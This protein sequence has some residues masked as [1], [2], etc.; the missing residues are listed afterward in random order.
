MEGSDK[1][2]SDHRLS[3]RGLDWRRLAVWVI[4]TIVGGP[5]VYLLPQQAL[6]LI[7]GE[8]WS[9]LAIWGVAGLICGALAGLIVGVGQRL[10]L[11]GVVSWTNEWVRSTVIGWAV[12]GAILMLFTRIGYS[13]IVEGSNATLFIAGLLAWFGCGAGIGVGQWLVLRQHLSKAGWWIVASSLGWGLS[14]LAA[15]VA[16]SNGPH[17]TKLMETGGIIGVATILL[18]VGPVISSI[19]GIITGLALRFLIS[20]ENRH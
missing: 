10:A 17:L 16:I 13:E 9:L 14:S 1:V 6:A 15:L 11:R 4:T 12:G 3:R 18:L 7:D 20:K 5:I 8:D 19:P 2:V